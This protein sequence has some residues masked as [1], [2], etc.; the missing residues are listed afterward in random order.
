M[1]I[2]F[3]IIIIAAAIFFSMSA[4]QNR[5]KQKSAWRRLANTHNLTYVSDDSF[6]GNGAYVTGNYRG[7]S[8]RL[9]TVEIK[10]GK[11]SVTYTRVSLFVARWPK[12][13]GPKDQAGSP[14]SF[15][16]ALDRIISFSP[17]FSLSEKFKAEPGGQNVYYQQK[18]VIEDTKFLEYLF[19]ILASLA[20]AYPVVVA[21]GGEAVSALNSV[22]AGKPTE[23]IAT[24]LLR[25]IAHD[26]SRLAHHTSV[27]L[28]PK[29]LTRFGPH[30]IDLS[31]EIDPTYY[32]CRTCGQSREFLNGSVIAL[33]D[34]QLDTTPIQQDGIVRVNWLAH[35]KLFDFDAVEVAQATDED[36]ERFAVQVGNDTDATRKSRYKDMQCVINSNSKLSENTL[37]ILRRTFGQMVAADNEQRPTENESGLNSG[38]IKK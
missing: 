11:S 3:W 18:G 15:Q 26:T 2:F 12:N 24:Q 9:E 32:G 22:F 25:D 31:W 20:E 13:S 30:K 5:E 33:L 21:Y 1:D 35:R 38:L 16:D 27:L 6:F 10:Q 19:E 29:C 8:L 37:R 17:H 36:V 34:N 23:E 7:C 28:C 4:R 14:L